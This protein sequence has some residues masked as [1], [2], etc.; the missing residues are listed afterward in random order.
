MLLK[1]TDE[2]LQRRIQEKSSLAFLKKLDEYAT[3]LE[4]TSFRPED[5][6]INGYTISAGFIEES[7]KK[8]RGMPVAER[9]REVA[10][11]IEHKIGI[12]H[13]YDLTGGERAELKA[14]LK[15][16]HNGSTLR[17]AYKNF[18]T[19]LGKPE[20]YKPAKNSI[21]EYADVFPLIY[22]KMRL[23]G[24]H[25]VRKDVKHLV[26]DEMQDYTPVQYAVISKLFP[27]RKTILGDANQSV[28]P[29][30]SSTSEEIRKV[31]RQADC[32][33]LCKSYRSTYEITQFAQRIS[34][35]PDLVAI[36]RHGDEP[37]VLGF[38]S[39]VEETE[40]ILRL[41]DEFLDRGH[42][43]MGIICKTFLLLSC[44]A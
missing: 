14:S 11:G 39:S 41:I 3:H 40:G 4:Q 37:R 18:F 9:L 26:I 1:K 8:Y 19:W 32:V 42:H 13:N 23:E 34:P 22:L 43:S 20:L 12:S 21:L 35:N 44:H 27:C 15:K 24:I 2:K 10:A 25:G 29:F 30:S 33:K 6:R 36:E 5:V 17:A 38:Q 28:N 31:F 7:F 16:M